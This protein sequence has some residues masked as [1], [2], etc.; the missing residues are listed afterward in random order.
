[1]PANQ[2]LERAQCIGVLLAPVRRDSCLPIYHHRS[3]RPRARS[4]RV[5]GLSTKIEVF[6]AHAFPL[7]GALGFVLFS[8]GARKHSVVQV[9]LLNEPALR[10][11]VVWMRAAVS[12]TSGWLG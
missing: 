7:P 4:S 1:M 10:L 9:P 12:P 3:L 11:A 5:L 2:V 6:P 8:P